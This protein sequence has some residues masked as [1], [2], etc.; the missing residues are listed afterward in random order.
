MI[1]SAL[2]VDDD[3]IFREALSASLE[4]RGLVVKRTGDGEGALQLYRE[5]SQDLVI[6]DFRM[7]R[8]DGISLLRQMHVVNP[9][10]VFVLLTGF[11]TIPLA[12]EA[13]KEGA[14]S[15]LT[16]PADADAILHEARRALE[17]KRRRLPGLQISEQRSYDLGILERVGIEKALE[18]TKGNVSRA[19]QLLG[20]DRRTLQRKMKRLFFWWFLVA[21][22]AFSVNSVPARAEGGGAQRLIELTGDDE[23]RDEQ[24]GWDKTYARRGYVFGKDPAPFLVKQLAHLPKGL[25]LDIAMGEGRNAVFLAKK[26]FLVEGVDISSVAVRKSQELAAES[27]VKIRAKVADL[28]KYRIEPRRY[29]VILNFYYL[30]RSL[31]PGIK[32]GLKKG[33]VVVFETHTVEHLRNPGA[34]GWS[35][36]FLLLPGELRQMFRDFEILHYAETNDG[37]DAVASLVARKP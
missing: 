35:R 14:D 23:F 1:Q 16:K 5:H 2:I 33:G 28:R 17:T 18:A 9:S 3:E 20:I 25:A 21:A 7:P 31:V 34:A 30:Q 8:L 27:K 37:R 13:M 32:E 36:D 24:S 29:D 6:L 19:A 15:V 4:K 10:A 22:C 12:V 26:G 11:G